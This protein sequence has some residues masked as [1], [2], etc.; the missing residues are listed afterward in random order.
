MYE[1]YLVKLPFSEKLTVPSKQ[2]EM[3]KIVAAKWCDQGLYVWSL[4]V[5]KADNNKDLN[6]L[7]VRFSPKML[8]VVR[9][10]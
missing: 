10:N 9:V 2:S 1:T 5:G 7:S 3:E 8:S 6:V 4:I